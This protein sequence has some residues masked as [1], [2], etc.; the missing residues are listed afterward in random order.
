MWIGCD[1]LE[2]NGLSEE[3]SKL[4]QIEVLLNS[5]QQR[6]DESDVRIEGQLEKLCAKLTARL[7]VLDSRMREAESQIQEHSLLLAQLNTMLKEHQE[8]DSY[9]NQLI[10]EA[11][12]FVLAAIIGAVIVKLVG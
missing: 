10:R 2:V 6:S 8:P 7:E 12:I 4:A 11:V 3:E 1:R 5:L 9:F